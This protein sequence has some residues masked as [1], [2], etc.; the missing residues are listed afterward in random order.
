MKA[1][2]RRSYHLRRQCGFAWAFVVRID[3]PPHEFP[4]AIGVSIDGFRYLAATRHDAAHVIRWYRRITAR[5]VYHKVTP[6][7]TLATANA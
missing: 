6:P 5:A 3:P 7:A 2:R 1:N 4:L